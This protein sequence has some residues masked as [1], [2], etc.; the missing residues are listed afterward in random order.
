[1]A[2]CWR[3][4]LIVL[5]VQASTALADPFR[6][7]SGD[8]L[9]PG[10]VARLGTIRFRQSQQITDLAFLPHGE[11][12]TL[13]EDGS[14]R[15]FD[16]ATGMLGRRFEVPRQPPQF[17]RS[18]CV[19][20]DGA[21]V[22]TVGGILKAPGEPPL[23]SLR[24][25]NTITGAVEKTLVWE[26]LRRAQCTRAAF[27]PDSDKILS[28]SSDGTLRIWDWQVG[29]EQLSFRIC[30]RGLQDM[31]LSPDGVLVAAMDRQGVIYLWNRAAGEMP[32]QLP[33]VPKSAAPLAFSPDG[34]QLACVGRSGPLGYVWDVETAT[35]IRTVNT[36][37]GEDY[38]QS[39]TF[40][41][42]GKFLCASSLAQKE[43]FVWDATTGAEIRR[44]KTDPLEPNLLAISPDS[45]WIATAPMWHTFWRAWNL[46]TGEIISPGVPANDAHTTR[47][48]FSPDGETLYTAGEDY[49]A[50]AWESR[51][52]RQ[53][54]LERHGHWVR[55]LALSHDG[56]FA[57]TSSLDDTVR[58]LDASDGRQIH[59]LPGH[60]HVGG[61]REVAFRL[62]DRD[63]VSWGDDMHLRI[64]DVATGET[65]SENVLHPDGLDVPEGAAGALERA[66]PGDWRFELGPA[67][68]TPDGRWFVVPFRNSFRVFDI[69][70]GKQDRSFGQIE[71]GYKD[72]ALSPTGSLLLSS[73]WVSQGD[74]HLLRLCDLASGEKRFEWKVWG[75]SAGPVTFSPDGM[76]FAAASGGPQ[77]RVAIYR[78]E[79]EEPTLTLP[80]MPA[81]VQC[82][83]I[84]PDA[85]LLATGL[86]DTTVL[87]WDL[88][89][90]Y[91]AQVED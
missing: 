49:T 8:P 75:P 14:L 41:P 13:G 57:A 70:T 48:I 39:V 16:R 59:S 62:G 4:L 91:S 21:L 55:G 56:R 35:L 3:I 64:W 63:L 45:Q 46:R 15:I 52:G 19:S 76:R 38:G 90:D 11:L 24:I 18:M 89:A 27:L 85:R 34:K 67:A 9:P 36:D 61:R 20:R 47:L 26:E 68:A 58:L 17:S 77:P 66:Q 43:I 23:A 42:D 30:D 69:A 33:R 53:R 73:E 28:A 82:M 31:A 2:R 51:T 83:A 88:D 87:V 78:P 81:G 37:K 60:G 44:L 25:W 79:A 12:L 40:S 29:Q 50:R 54:W 7:L 74:Y 32:K 1:M 22:V 10:V 71:G 65:S 72:V 5:S 84:S 6:D 80:V 86:R